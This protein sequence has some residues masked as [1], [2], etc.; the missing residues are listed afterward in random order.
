MIV[1]I[2]GVGVVGKTLQTWF[3]KNT[4]HDLRLYDPNKNFNDSLEGCEAIFVSIPVRP[5]LGGQQLTELKAVVDMAKIYTQFVFI[6]STVLPGTCDDLG[7]IAMPEFLTERCAQEDMDKFPIIIGECH[8]NLAK[9]IFLEKEII[10][11]KNKEAELAKFAHN[12]FGAMKVTFFNII[13]QIC[14]GFDIDY[15]KVKQGFLMTGH[16]NEQHTKVPGPDGMF[17]YGG[18]CFPEN[19]QAFTGFLDTWQMHHEATLIAQVARLNRSYRQEFRNKPEMGL[20]L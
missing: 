9:A 14:I 1:G 20:E 13:N 5:S 3:E 10:F 4:K 17:G 2:I 16:V 18:K 6:R 15:S 19:I 8:P 7:C 12:C 11:M